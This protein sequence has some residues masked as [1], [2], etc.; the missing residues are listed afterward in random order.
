MPGSAKSSEIGEFSEIEGENEIM[1]CM[2]LKRKY[3]NHVNNC[4]KCSQQ[5]GIVAYF[6]QIGCNFAYFL[7]CLCAC[8][9]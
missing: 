2:I 6:Y 9:Q 8:P 1:F 3:A 5:A 4:G 7:I